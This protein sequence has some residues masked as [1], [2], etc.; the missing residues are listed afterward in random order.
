MG[1]ER[2][3]KSTVA[4]SLQWKEFDEG[5][6]D[7]ITAMGWASR[8]DPDELGIAIIQTDALDQKSARKVLY[9]VSRHL[10][11]HYSI[12][13]DYAKRVVFSALQEYLF[14][15]C[16]Y[17]GGKGELHASNEVVSG[18]PH[19]HGSGK[20]RYSNLERSVLLGKFRYR[21]KIYEEALKLI[22]DKAGRLVSQAGARLRDDPVP[23]T[24]SRG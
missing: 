21:E 13:R 10:V 2:L 20:H 3:I 14:P 15:N 4:H 8:Y 18:C 23:S 7:Q 22:R 19:C 1:R 9:L 5:A 24:A 11:R 12:H 17:C 6:V 16:L